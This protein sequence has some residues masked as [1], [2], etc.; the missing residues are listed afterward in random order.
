MTYNVIDT[1]G[2]LSKEEKKIIKKQIRKELKDKEK[3]DKS[4]PAYAG[5]AKTVSPSPVEQVL[6]KNAKIFAKTLWI[7]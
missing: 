5:G 2:T 7:T 3:R 6:P 1:H 4:L